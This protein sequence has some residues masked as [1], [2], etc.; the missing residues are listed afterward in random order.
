MFLCL[1]LDRCPARAG[2]PVLVCCIVPFLANEPTLLCFTW[3]VN[4]LVRV[5]F[6]VLQK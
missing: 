5:N 3:E 1:R 6:S 4:V 2:V